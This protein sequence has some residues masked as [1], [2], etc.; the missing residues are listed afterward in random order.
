MAIAAAFP[1]PSDWERKA[2]LRIR[3]RREQLALSQEQMAG[4]AGMSVRHYKK[5]E[6]GSIDPRL[7]SMFAIAHALRTTVGE[8]AD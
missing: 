2:A 1:N 4:D 3:A 6:G 5:V 8:I 7:T